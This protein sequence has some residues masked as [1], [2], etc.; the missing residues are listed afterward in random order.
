MTGSACRRCGSEPRAGA[1]FCDACGSPIAT[2]ANHAE[3]KQVTVLFVDVQRSMDLAAALGPERLREVMGDIF[4]RCGAVIQRYGGTVEQFTGDGVMALFGAPIALEDHAIRACVAALEI[5][6]EAGRLAEEVMHRDRMPVALRVGLNSGDVVFGQIGSSSDSYTAFGSPVGMAQ[7]MESV[8]PA[9]GVMISESTA[10]LVEH[11]AVLDE[12][13]LVDIKN[14][15]QPVPARRLRGMLAS[16]AVAGRRE[17]TLVGRDDEIRS[18]TTIVGETIR[19]KGSVVNL[20]GPAGI[21]KSRFCRELVK[22]AQTAGMQTVSSFCES[23]ASEA[24]FGVV[25]KL[26]RD[27]MQ[28]SDDERETG[29]VMLRSR[30]RNAAPDDLLLLE[31]L[32]GVRETAVA[33]PNISAEARRRR[34]AALIG[35]SVMSPDTPTGYVIEDV[36]WIDPASEALLVD[37][38]ASN[39]ARRAMVVIT[40]RPEY[41]GVL[42]QLPGAASIELAALDDSA[43]WEMTTELIGSHPSVTGL[44]ANIIE[45]SAGNPFYV[46]EIVREFAERK[47]IVGNR[48]AYRR[49]LDIADISVPPTLQAT[50]G[51]RIDRLTPAAKRTLNAAAIIGSRFAVDLL[52]A[53]LGDTEESGPTVLAELVHSE[54]IDQLVFTP[55]AEYGFRHPL[56]RTVAYESQLK[57]ARAQLHRRLAATLEHRHA[58]AADDIA[59]V[60]ARHLEAGGD[61]REAFNWHMRAGNW[62]TNRD[63]GAARNS[64]QRAKALADELATDDPDRRWMRTV[65]RAL[66]CGSTWR[67]GGGLADTGFEELRAL[68]T[69]PEDQVPLAMGMAGYLSQLAV[70]GRIREAS[71]A[72][73]E[74]VG[75]IDSIDQPGLTVGMLYPAIHA[76]YEAAEMADVERLAQRVVDLAQGDPTKGNFLTG[77]PLAYATGMV[78]SARCAFGLPGW[79]EG[80]DRAIEISRVDPTTYVSMVMF[81]FVL[82]IP[83]GALLADTGAQRDSAEALQIA[84]RCSEDFA[85]HSAEL[86]RAIVLLAASD[87]DHALGLDLLEKARSAAVNEDFMMAKVPTIDVQLAAQKARVNDLDGAIELSRHVIASQL[88]TGGALDLPTGTGVL[89]ESLLARSGIGD[90]DE[91][92][93]AVERLAAAKGPGFTLYALPVLRMQAML[94]SAQGDEQWYR[95]HAERYLA[96]ARA[97]Q[98]RGHEA[99]ARRM[100]G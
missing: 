15:A 41:G 5:Q 63:I 13:S 11:I 95:N 84:E 52:D 57:T 36:H 99:C 56:V 71:N 98:F 62:F 67:A 76:K 73:A 33:V 50:I 14:V 94:A 65:P 78:A 86:T 18:V 32:V 81:K 75:L 83:C 10:R 87:G 54:L 4:N 91:A 72:A 42:S 30:F 44:A 100:L 40:Y 60:I 70:V 92:C 43:A 89:V 49:Q 51:A 59:A 25:T 9:G 68:C 31:D 48:G 69:R 97:A 27:V 7:R 55:P 17:A 34:L 39:P 53:V 35:A 66:L 22:I 24:P 20:V 37:L 21:G 45:H 64:W 85:L 93:I 8:A 3:H 1:R 82:G 38:L 88:E 46:Q 29:R 90:L 28:I 6:K 19:G 12:P 74:Y 16:R 26:L 80:F 96:A 61:I 77:S 23:H 2:V 47:V 58:T 79:R